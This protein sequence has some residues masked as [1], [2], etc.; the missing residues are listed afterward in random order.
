MDELLA[1]LVAKSFGQKGG[2]ILDASG[3]TNWSSGD[4]SNPNK[5]AYAFVPDTDGT[6]GA[7]ATLDAN[8]IGLGGTAFKAGI[9]KY[10]VAK[11]ITVATGS[12]TLYF[13]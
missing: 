9:P 13:S 10:F 5:T 3:T 11:K 8:I 4:T 2:I 6:F 7:A 12:G 1:D